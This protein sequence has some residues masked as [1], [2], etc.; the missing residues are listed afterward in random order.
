LPTTFLIYLPIFLQD[1]QFLVES[2]S[3]LF[4]KRSTKKS[5][6]QINYGIIKTTFDDWLKESAKTKENEKKAWLLE[7]SEKLLKGELCYGILVSL[8]LQRFQINSTTLLTFY[9]LA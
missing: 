4:D 7:F 6:F 9:F 2:K 1:W 3:R 8:P 5:K